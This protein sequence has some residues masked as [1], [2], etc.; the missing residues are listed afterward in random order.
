MSERH[1]PLTS[2]SYFTRGYQCGY[3]QAALDNRI[4]F[5]QDVLEANVGELVDILK[6]AGVN[7]RLGPVVIKK[8][9][10]RWVLLE[11]IYDGKLS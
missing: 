2:D 1:E 10:I 5:K 3:L 4:S 8:Y 11:V 9:V 6:Q 7:Y